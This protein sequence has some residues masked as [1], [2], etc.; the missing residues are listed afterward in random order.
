MVRSNQVNLNIIPL[1]PSKYVLIISEFVYNQEY[2]SLS[3]LLSET[4]HEKAALA[5][6]LLD[7]YVEVVALAPCPVIF[8]TH[9]RRIVM[10][11]YMFLLSATCLLL[12]TSFHAAAQTIG[13]P[14]VLLIVRE[15]I[16]PGMMPD[17]SREANNVVRIYAKAKS[18]WHRLAMT[19]VAG[20]ENEVMYFWGFDSFADMERSNKDLDNMANVTFKKDFDNIRPPGED[21]HSSQRDAIA[22][23]R[24]DLSYNAGVDI[25]KMRYMR[26]QTVRVKP[27]HGRDFEEGRRILNA[28]HVKA[29][30][31]EHMAVYQIMGGAQTG[32]YLVIIPWASLD[33][34]ATIPHG[35]DYWDAMGDDN[36]NKM[37]KV[38][39]ESIVFTATDVYAFAPQLSYASERIVASDPAFWTLKPMSAP[40]AS[41]KIGGKK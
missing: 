13:P 12:L 1:R 11:K 15:E 36:R 23:F 5:A 2:R 10:K 7:K 22:V 18:P 30:I 35:K 17:H 25:A 33:G 32:T 19:P 39:S 21:Y 8:R 28:A 31:D 16:K 27:G 38:E 6:L 24:P 29:K 14:K 34:M 40:P 26:I 4:E 3:G 20:N 9:R 37:E 41:K